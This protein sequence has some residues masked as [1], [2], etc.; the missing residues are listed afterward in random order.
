MGHK[1]RILLYVLLGGL[2]LSSCSSPQSSPGPRLEVVQRGE[3]VV[4]HVSGG[5]GELVDESGRVIARVKDGEDVVLDN[6]SNGAH[7]ISLGGTSLDM[8][9]DYPNG[10]SLESGRAV[11]YWQRIGGDP[12]VDVSVYDTNNDGGFT[13]YERGM[14]DFLLRM[15]QAGF[16]P[17]EMQRFVE[18]YDFTD[19]ETGRAGGGRWLVSWLNRNLDFYLAEKDF[20]PQYA[21]FT[22]ETIGFICFSC[23]A[24]GFGVPTGDVTRQGFSPFLPFPIHDRATYVGMMDWYQPEWMKG[25]NGFLSAWEKFYGWPIGSGEDTY[26]TSSADVSFLRSYSETMQTLPHLAYRLGIGD[27]MVKI[28]G[29][30]H[31]ERDYP[32]DV[33]PH[34]DIQLDWRLW[35]SPADTDLYRPYSAF[36]GD[37]LGEHPRYLYGWNQ[38]IVIPDADHPDHARDRFEAMVGQIGDYISGNTLLGW[39]NPFGGTGT[40]VADLGYYV[41]KNDLHDA[42]PPFGS[43]FFSLPGA[44]GRR[45]EYYLIDPFAAWA[46]KPKERPFFAELSAKMPCNW[47]PQPSSAGWQMEPSACAY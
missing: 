12:A 35:L 31:A 41:L 46:G 1:R 26:N 33:K 6:L 16:S 11:E 20:A 9:I 25:G 22:P 5:S 37:G 40:L 36:R 44:G 14:L 47:A 2:F 17:A 42:Q 21:V 4:V 8:V 45:K 15:Q 7:R 19:D 23:V 43:L 29:I 24:E 13:N 32:G 27:V 30:A 39:V 34:T 10:Y 18:Y 3:P 28:V 38:H